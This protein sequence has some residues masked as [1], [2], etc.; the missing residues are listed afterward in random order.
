MKNVKGNHRGSTTDTKALIDL[1]HGQDSVV[2]TTTKPHKRRVRKGSNAAKRG[3]RAPCGTA[4]GDTSNT[5]SQPGEGLH[6]DGA[7]T[8]SVVASCRMLEPS[9]TR[10]NGQKGSV[11]GAQGRGRGSRKPAEEAVASR[12]AAHDGVVEEGGGGQTWKVEAGAFPVCEETGETPGGVARVLRASVQISVVDG[13]TVVGR[14]SVDGT[15][16]PGNGEDIPNG[17]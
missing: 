9:T 13:R 7:A 16:G 11:V 12:V 8:V 17:S 15:G 2:H 1:G 14:D 3:E 6:H 4:A 5:R 10:G